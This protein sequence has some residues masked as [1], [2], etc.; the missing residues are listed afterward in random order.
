MKGVQYVLYYLWLKVFTQSLVLSLIESLYTVS[1]IITDWKSLHSLW[2]YHWLKISSIITDWKSLVLSLIE[3]L[4][5]VSGIITD[6]KSL[7]LSL[8]ES[9]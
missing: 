4:Y 7:V 1:S 2:Y 8:I 5:T 3:S 6:W 9:L